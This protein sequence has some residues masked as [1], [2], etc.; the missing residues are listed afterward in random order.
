MALMASFFLIVNPNC[1]E[2]RT[3]IREARQITK[4]TKLDRTSIFVL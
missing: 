3:E 2:A 1:G 4:Y